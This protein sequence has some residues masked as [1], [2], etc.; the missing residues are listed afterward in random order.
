MP[1][2]WVVATTI[3]SNDFI[4][5]SQLGGL[6]FKSTTDAGVILTYIIR[7][8]WSKNLLTS[9]LAFDISQFFP[10]LNHHLL[11]KIIQKAGLNIHVI[12]F[13][14]NYL[15]NKKTN[16][17][18]NNFSSHIFDVNVSIG[19]SSF[20]YFISVISFTISLYFRKTSKK[21]SYSN[22]YHFLHWQWPIYFSGQISQN[23]QCSS[24]L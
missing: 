11:T 5:P 10:S 14:N 9:T 12:D 4:H 24:F 13:F 7:L 1:F 8:G 17:L 3:A 19:F 16:Y 22:L 21:S 15:I 2:Q 6:K 23:V 18:W 20:F